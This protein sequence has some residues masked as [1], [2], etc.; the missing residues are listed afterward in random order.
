[1]KTLEEVDKIV[2]VC[3]MCVPE[4]GDTLDLVATKLRAIG[5][6]HVT[7]VRE[8]AIRLRKLDSILK[9]FEE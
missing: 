2:K 4:A 1:M 7:L 9:G 5:A 3:E 6:C 8:L